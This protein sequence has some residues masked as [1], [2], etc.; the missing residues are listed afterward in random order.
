M[1][2]IL[3]YFFGKE[4][5]R[6]ILLYS[7]LLLIKRSSLRLY[8]YSR[9]KDFL[10]IWFMNNDHMQKSNQ[11]KKMWYTVI[12]NV[13]AKYNIFFCVKQLMS[14]QYYI[15]LYLQN[16]C[17]IMEW[18]ISLHL[19][20]FIFLCQLLLLIWAVRKHGSMV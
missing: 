17:F 20:Y 16:R 6:S 10:I 9:T 12:L 5:P 11:W 15:I 3:C 14:F 19:Y 1:F 7:H 4:L 13:I 2:I 18:T 8:G